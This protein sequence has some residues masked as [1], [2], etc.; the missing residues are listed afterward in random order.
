M[1][2]W[3]LIKSPFGVNCGCH[4][5]A[6]CNGHGVRVLATAKEARHRIRRG[7]GRRGD[8]FRTVEESRVRKPVPEVFVP[9]VTVRVMLCP[10]A[11]LVV[12]HASMDTAGPERKRSNC[13]VSKKGRARTH[14]NQVGGIRQKLV[15]H[16]CEGA[17]VS[18]HVA[19]TSQEA[20]S[21]KAAGPAYHHQFNTSSTRPSAG[22]APTST[23]AF[24]Y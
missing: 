23:V 13:M 20:T 17:S 19:T 16:H 8:D 2:H 10:G 9:P 11:M 14:Q 5:V 24:P 7:D 12:Q 6:H 22:H 18:P 15:G 3:S 1:L 4:W 21:H